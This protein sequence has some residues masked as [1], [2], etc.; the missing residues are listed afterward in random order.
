MAAKRTSAELA[1]QVVVAAAI[2]L[3]K[4]KLISRISAPPSSDHSLTRG[5]WTN[6]LSLI[7]TI[8]QKTN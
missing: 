1:S 2:R 4:T 8:L 7:L 6:I 5:S 3:Q